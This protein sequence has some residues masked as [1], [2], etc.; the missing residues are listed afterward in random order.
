MNYHK[1]TFPEAIKHLGVIQEVYATSGEAGNALILL[2]KIYTEQGKYAEADE[3]FKSVLQI[4]GW[5]SL[6][7]EALYC[8]GDN[9]MAQ[10]RFDVASAYYERIY[11][12]YGHYRD[13]MAKAY[14]R[15]A[16]CL[17]KGFQEAKAREV[18]HEML[19]NPDLAGR[20]ELSE[21][22]KLLGS[23]GGAAG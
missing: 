1:M 21:A 10:R 3:C 8:R 22:R 5:R 18:L 9:A 4:K 19:D 6:W 23:G 7:P 12:M 14:L 17:I 15:R 16:E 20:P 13:W 2:G 11:L